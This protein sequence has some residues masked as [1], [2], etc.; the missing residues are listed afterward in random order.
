MEDKQD[1]INFWIT[2]SDRDAVVAQDTFHNGHYHYA[3]FF[4]QLVIEKLLKA[5]MIQ[6]TEEYPL[7]AHDLVKLA[8]RAKIELSEEQRQQFLEI[9]TFNLEARY[10][11][12]KHAFYEKATQE[13]AVKWIAICKEIQQW[14]KQQL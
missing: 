11:N 14:L 3:L 13:Y 12:Y 10:D 9:T 5:L 4:W 1:K 8:K 7:P 6:N 2:S